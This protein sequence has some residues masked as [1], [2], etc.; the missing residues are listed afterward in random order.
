[1]LL[2]SVLIDLC[3]DILG[4]LNEKRTNAPKQQQQQELPGNKN[5]R[6]NYAHL[7]PTTKLNSL[8]LKVGT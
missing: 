1:M 5:F 2:G 6:Y 7:K 4:L 3:Y 8:I